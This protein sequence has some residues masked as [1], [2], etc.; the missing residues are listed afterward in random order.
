MSLGLLRAGFA[1]PGGGGGAAVVE[2]DVYGPHTFTTSEAGYAGYTV[3]MVI[4]AD[5]MASAG[6][7]GTFV[8]VTIEFTGF[9]SGATLS[10]AYWGETSD[11]N[12][13]I[14][15]NGNQ[16]QITFDGGSADIVGDGAT[17]VYVSDW[18]ELGEEYDETKAHIFAAEFVNTGTVNFGRL[19][20]GS[21]SDQFFY[22]FAADA[23]TTD[24]S[25][26]SLQITNTPVLVSRVEIATGDPEG[27]P[28]ITAPI[29]TSSNT[30]SVVED[31]PLAHSL[32]AN[33]SVTWTII[34]GADQL[35]FE[36]AGSTLRWASNGT[37]DFDA[38]DDADLNN[39]YIVQVRAT[40]TSANTT[41]QTITVTVTQDLPA[42]DMQFNDAANSALIVVL[43][44][45]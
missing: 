38:P 26:Y 14:D 23:A 29:I 35:E 40:D 37:K 41:D 36:I 3:V 6:G 7:T 31:N 25:G 22:K 24:K 1:A 13:G 5:N 2:S 12:L 10:A 45:F 16:N 9:S 33:E 18:C 42:P 19:L 27:A 30:A 20:S 43:E 32:T 15:F 44:D 11:G 39:A 8:R 17:L 4:S 28:D 34:G 21:S